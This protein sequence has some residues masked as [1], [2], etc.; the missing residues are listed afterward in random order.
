LGKAAGTQGGS[1]RVAQPP[2]AHTQNALLTPEEF[3]KSARDRG[4][5]LG[6]EHLAELHRRRALVALLRVVQRPSKAL[7]PMPV[8][9]SAMNGY[10]FRS[11]IALVTGRL[12]TGM[13]ERTSQGHHFCE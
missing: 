2:L 5:G 8:A 6:A 1:A 3:T 7:P 13:S 12:L 11:P 4:L 10:Q 9:T